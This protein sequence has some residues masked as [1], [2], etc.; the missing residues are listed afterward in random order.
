MRFSFGLTMI[1]PQYN[2]AG[3]CDFSRIIYI[4]S[5]DGNKPIPAVA[6]LDEDIGALETPEHIWDATFQV[7]VKGNWWGT[8]YAI[9]AMR[10]NPTDEGKGLKVGG[11]IINTASMV[12]MMGSAIPQLACEFGF[13]F[14]FV[15]FS[16]E[17][18]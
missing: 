7:V 10:Q 2:N 17:V 8:K 12:A 13:G 1:D 14:S 11:S 5:F 4:Y 9:L 18:D 3:L 15:S 16:P 6:Y